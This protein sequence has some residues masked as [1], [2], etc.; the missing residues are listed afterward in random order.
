MKSLLES[1]LV[2]KLEHLKDLNFVKAKMVYQSLKA[3]YQKMFFQNYRVSE[4]LIQQLKFQRICCQME[5]KLYLRLLRTFP[6]CLVRLTE[7]L[8]L[9]KVGRLTDLQKKIKEIVG[10]K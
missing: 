6:K 3:F 1:F 10:W 7:S 2:I 5:H 8:Y 4:F 9:Q